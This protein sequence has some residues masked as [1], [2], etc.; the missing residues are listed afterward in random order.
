MKKAVG[1]SVFL[2][3]FSANGWAQESDINKRNTHIF[4]SSHLALVGES[5]DEEEDQRQALS[6]LSRMHREAARE[7]GATKEHFDDVAGYL[8]TVRSDDEAK[9]SIL[10]AQ[11]RD[12]CLPGSDGR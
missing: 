2:V 1:L 4:C 11:S 9:W 6:T 8:K 5:L 7:L 10:S 12:I 3:V